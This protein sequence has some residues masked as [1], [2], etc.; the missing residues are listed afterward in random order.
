MAPGAAGAHVRRPDDEREGKKA[1]DVVDHAERHVPDGLVTADGATW[2][3]KH[4][5]VSRS[6]VNDK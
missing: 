5:F 2:M 3:K 6:V 4:E 1:G